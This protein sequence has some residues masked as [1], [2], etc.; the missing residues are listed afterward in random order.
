MEKEENRNQNIFKRQS[1]REDKKTERGDEK[2]E[3]R[4]ETRFVV[5]VLMFLFSGV[6]FFF[7]LFYSLI[8]FILMCA[9]IQIISFA[10]FTP[11]LSFHR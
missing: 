4:D 6:Q 5:D 8:F 7:L 11:S 1:M 2:N 9:T 10:F 3:V